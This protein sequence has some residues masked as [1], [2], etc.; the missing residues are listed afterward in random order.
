MGRRSP[1]RHPVT[2]PAERRF[3]VAINAEALALAWIRQE[4][5]PTGAI[6]VPDHEVS[7]RGRLGRLWTHPQEGTA[8]LA[9]V[10]RPDL[11]ADRADLV[12]LAASLGLLA[13]A[14]ALTGNPALGLWWPDRLVDAGEDEVGQIRAE[15]QLGPGRVTSTVV[16][17]RLDLAALGNFDRSTATV[18][19]TDGLLDAMRLCDG[20][21]E[22]LCEAY[23]V[24]CVL[25]GRRVVAQLL[26]RGTARGTVRGF[27]VLGRLELASTTGLVERIP[28]D[29]LNELELV[30]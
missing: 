20:D 17:A 9:M 29:N 16:T 15:V 4:A 21:S 3:P 13:G 25:S 30:V 27:D 26:P 1:R 18:A 10:W 23:R 24:S 8:V 22:A 2:G 5:A 7:P 28:L 6:V 11:D 12:W 19:M 14:R